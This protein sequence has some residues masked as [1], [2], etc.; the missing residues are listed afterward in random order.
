MRYLKQGNAG[1]AAA[2]NRGAA[3]AEG[4][5]LA[6]LDSDDAFLPGKLRAFRHAIAAEWD[7]ERTVWY[8]PLLFF[9]GEGVQTA[10]PP[11]AI[12]PGERVGDYLFASR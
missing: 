1:A 5:Y 10:K 3:A 9:R 7:D 6:F 4:R 12:G 11:R 8:S 2:R